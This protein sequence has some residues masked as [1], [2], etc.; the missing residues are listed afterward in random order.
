MAVVKTFRTALN[1]FNRQD[2]V[3]YIEYMNNRHNSQLQQ[4]NNQL[5]AAQAKLDGI[6]AQ[7]DSIHARLAEGPPRRIHRRHR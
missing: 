4:L 2:V 6:H 5:A 7:I 3:K 1:G